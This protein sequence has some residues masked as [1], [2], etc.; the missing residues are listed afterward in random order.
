MI[1]IVSFP[2]PPAR[3]IKSRGTALS[4]VHELHHRRVQRA[5]ELRVQLRLARQRRQLRDLRRLTARPCTTAALIC[6]VGVVLPN[7]VQRL[8]ERDRIR[9]RVR[10][11]RRPLEELVERLERG[12]LERAPGDRVSS[13]PW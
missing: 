4:T 13:R 6:S 2:P 5:E 7:V 1:P 9:V 11:R 10:D 8:G 3:F 12:A